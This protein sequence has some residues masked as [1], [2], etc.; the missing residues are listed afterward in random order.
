MYRQ[1]FYVYGSHIQG[2]VTW[3][4]SSVGSI[5]KVVRL[6]HC[7]WKHAVAEGLWGHVPQ[8][9]FIKGSVLRSLLRLL[10]GHNATKIFPSAQCLFL[11]TCGKK[12][13]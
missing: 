4:V 1:Y 2:G 5:F 3:P 9:K 7:V 8:G 10:L 11:D 6:L 12:S 13:H